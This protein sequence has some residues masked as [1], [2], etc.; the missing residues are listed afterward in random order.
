MKS[1][2]LASFPLWIVYIN[3]ILVCYLRKQRSVK[4][5]YKPIYS[6]LRFCLHLYKGQMMCNKHI[7]TPSF[8]LKIGIQHVLYSQYSTSEN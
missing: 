1:V 6:V 5:L 3:T 8:I 2:C 7:L 4:T